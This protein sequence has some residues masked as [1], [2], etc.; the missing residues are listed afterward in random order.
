MVK[1]TLAK[2]KAIY[3]KVL[4]KVTPSKSELAD[5]KKLFI[6]IK[7]EVEGLEG[8]HSHLEWCG[9]S[10]RGTHLKGDR[11]LDLF[12][13]FDKELSE[14]EFEK[15][16]LRIG[17]EIFNGGTWEIAYSQHPYVRGVIR[18]FDVEIVP[19]YIVKNGFEKKSAVDRT[20]FHNKFL[21]EKMKSAQRQDARL[22]KQF[23]KGIKAYGADLK[24]QAL[25]GYGVELLVLKYGSFN[26]ALEKI[27]KWGEQE[28]V[29]LKKRK[30]KAN[31]DFFTPLIIID[32]VDENRNVAS[33]LS[34]EQ[35]ERMKIAAKIFLEEPNEKFFFGS[36][37]EIWPKELIQ[38][39]LAKREF[40]AI[41]ANFP[42]NILAD[43]MWGQLRRY[44]R[45]ATSS[46]EEKD[47]V[48]KKTNLWSDEKKV[49]YL[50]ELNELKLDKV[51]K[52]V[53]PMKKDKENTKRFLEKKRK[54]LKK[55]TLEGRVVLE[56]ERKDRAAQKVLEAF[57]SC[58]DEEKKG[59]KNCLKKAKV[60][61]EKD[62]LKHY[63]GEFAKHLTK[64]LEGKEFFE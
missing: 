17:K 26:K 21:L 55:Y 39:E 8:K 51:K 36:T 1:K 59:M 14:K 35:Y 2:R 20:P 61:S 29:L 18:G 53:G 22:L 10:A 49:F 25:P 64:Y 23:L 5:E 48:V 50:F 9:S 4:A 12:L 24:N 43:L 44:L 27:A 30:R 15:E 33:A 45:K 31:E 47:F 63:K 46:L 60:L 38:K 57:V 62:I 56:V 34:K 3:K 32:P 52:V 13:M 58:S 6:S 54:I 11:D 7:K 40:L 37:V 19:G 42:K 16:G 41:E 28:I